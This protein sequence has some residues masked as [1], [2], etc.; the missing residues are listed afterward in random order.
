MQTIKAN[1][2]LPL[3]FH[4]DSTAWKL[5]HNR[6]KPLHCTLLLVCIGQI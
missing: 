3:A 5:F 4:M 6:V 2:A 1:G